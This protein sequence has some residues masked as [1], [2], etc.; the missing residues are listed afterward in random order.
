[1]DPYIRDYKN[2]TIETTLVDNICNYNDIQSNLPNNFKVFHVNIRSIY[3]NYDELCIFLSQ[4]KEKFDVIV[5][6]ETFQ[7]YDKNI[8]HMN[9]YNMIYNEGRINKNDGVVVFLRAH[10]EHNFKIIKIGEINALKINIKHENKN[11]IVTAVYRSP[12][13]DPSNFNDGLLNYL[14]NLEN[15]DLSIFVYKYRFILR[16]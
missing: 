13:T 16:K 11:I 3:K 7:I 6:S 14:N 5:L 2:R 9:G 4:F 12:N 10:L 15:N 1:M 8:F